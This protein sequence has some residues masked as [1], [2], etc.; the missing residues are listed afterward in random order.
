MA[1]EEHLAIL[2]QGM[3]VWNQ[4]RKENREIRPDLHHANLWGMNL[5]GRIPHER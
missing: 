2:K 3:E 4:W 1:N 5:H